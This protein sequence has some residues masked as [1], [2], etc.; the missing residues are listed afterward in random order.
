MTNLITNLRSTEVVM[1]M[2]LAPIWFHFSLAHHIGTFF[3]AK[4]Q[5]FYW[6][7]LT[8]AVEW[9]LVVFADLRFVVAHHPLWWYVMIISLW[10]H[11]E[12]NVVINTLKTWLSF[13]IMV[14]LNRCS[15][16]DKFVYRSGCIKSTVFKL[17]ANGLFIILSFPPFPWWFACS[18]LF[19]W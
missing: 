18:E 15:R 17:D 16:S 9:S 10:N 11:T 19:W 8:G 6:W 3:V 1:S 2:H 12:H 13:W 14:P 7:L 4:I 5:F